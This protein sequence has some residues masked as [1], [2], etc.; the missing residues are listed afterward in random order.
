MTDSAATSSTSGGTQGFVPDKRR[1][2]LLLALCSVVATFGALVVV[3]F[4]VTG[5]INPSLLDDKVA[6]EAEQLENFSTAA[7]SE[8]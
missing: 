8:N 5:L 3:A 6:N 1:A 2:G 4:L 7:G